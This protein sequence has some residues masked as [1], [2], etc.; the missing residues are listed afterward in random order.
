VRQ[1]HHCVL[2]HIKRI[3]LM[4]QCDLCDPECLP[5]DLG[6]KGFEGARAILGRLTQMCLPGREQISYL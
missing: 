3:R 4:T 5:L 1:L 2:Y 6:Q